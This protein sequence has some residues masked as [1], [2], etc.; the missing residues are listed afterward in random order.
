MLVSLP[1][2]MTI[3]QTESVCR[4]RMAYHRS[5]TLSTL[6]THLVQ[7]VDSEHEDELITERSKLIQ[8]SDSPL[9]TSGSTSNLDQLM[10]SYS[11]D[12]TQDQDTHW[13]NGKG[14]RAKLL[15]KKS[16]SN[17]GN[18]SSNGT[19]TSTGGDTVKNGSGGRSKRLGRTPS[20][21]SMLLN[22][23]KDRIREKVFQTSTEWPYAAAIIQERR[24]RSVD[25]FEAR[26]A[27]SRKSL[28]DIELEQVPL[29][30][31][32]DNQKRT[33]MKSE[34][35]P[36]LVLTESDCDISP[37]EVARL[38]F[39]RRSISEDTYDRRP[40]LP[41]VKLDQ[42]EN[43]AGII[44]SN[45]DLQAIVGGGKKKSP[46]V[47][48]RS[49]LEPQVSLESSSSTY[50]SRSARSTRAFSMEADLSP[51]ERVDLCALRGAESE[52]LNINLN[53]PGTSG[54]FSSQYPEV[55]KDT[56]PKGKRVSRSESL[57]SGNSINTLQ[58]TSPRGSKNSIVLSDRRCSDRSDYYDKYSQAN[59]YKGSGIESDGSVDNDC[60][61]DDDDDDDDDDKPKAVPEIVFDEFGQ[62][63]DVYG[64]EFDPEAVGDAIQRHL[65][66]LMTR[67]SED[68]DTDQSNSG[69]GK[70][71]GRA[72]SFW[73]K[74]LCLF[75]N[76][77]HNS[78]S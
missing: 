18:S 29:K 23:V 67:K 35:I 61:S 47:Q 39:R 41:I 68:S 62:T 40:C 24:Q 59:P 44:C 78:T 43:K 16:M 74:F 10:A 63:W 52:D 55:L 46:Q 26:V 13:N 1:C 37:A 4:R 33:R 17:P 60:N 9:H 11:E 75:N 25:A 54:Y 6:P 8:I 38:A 15:S 53:I 3:M 71:R 51:S 45:E 2:V 50:S 42:P 12:T 22:R 30:D 48:K 28:D 65:V 31:L 19:K 21:P 20:T 7:E 72:G 73:L 77:E 57:H 34:P 5:H 32:H 36:A 70:S 56:R 69:T 58:N 27:K 66:K 49:S 64:A 76:R 14:K